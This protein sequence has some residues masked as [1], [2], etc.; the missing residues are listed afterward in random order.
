MAQLSLAYTVTENQSN[1]LAALGTD[2]YFVYPTLAQVK[3]SGTSKL[4][5]AL[6][7]T[8]S[9]PAAYGGDTTSILT[10][11]GGTPTASGSTSR[12]QYVASGQA[13]KGFTITAPAGTGVRTLYLFLSTYTARVRVQAALSD[14]SS[15]AIS[16]NTKYSDSANGMMFGATITYAASTDGQTLTITVTNDVSD[17]GVSNVGIQGAAL[18]LPAGGGGGNAVPTFSGTIANITGT[19]GSAITPVSTASLFSDSDTLTYSASPAGTAWP[20]GL[21][22]NSSTG[23]ISGT[24]ATSTTTGLKV[25]ATDTANQ[26]AD[27]NAFSLTM[28]APST[29]GVMLTGALLSS[30]IPRPAGQA[31]LYTLMRGGVIGSAT[32]TVTH[33]SG[34]T[35]SAGKLSL[36]GLAAGAYQVLMRTDDNSVYYQE[37]TVA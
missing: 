24:V 37:I 32:G 35:N 11:T 9:G 31:V 36:T 21:V 20:S 16:D 12:G 2:D 28:A 30:D 17:T 10:W 6:I 15:A 13:G 14:G 23:V 5:F 4:A 34:I 18:S 22:V 1:D 25:R 7:A 19:G 29:A 33:G 27:S 26:T 8:T 3:K